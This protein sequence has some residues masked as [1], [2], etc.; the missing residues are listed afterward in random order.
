MPRVSLA[1]LISLLLCATSPAREGEVP[2]EQRPIRISTQTAEPAATAAG[3]PARADDSILDVGRLVMATGIVV[4]LIFG[5]RFGLRKMF[6]QPKHAGRAV[7]MLSRTP[8]SPRQQVMLLKV[9]SRVIVVGDSAGTMR[10]LSEITDPDEVALVIGQAESA[11]ANSATAF[12]SWLGVSRKKYEGEVMPSPE[13]AEITLSTGPVHQDETAG[14]SGEVRQL[15][16][17]VR[18][19]SRQM[20]K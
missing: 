1:I 11:T 7:Q 16:E 19:I 18:S 5:L 3:A 15:L 13:D 20:G 6:V 9:G 12:Q 4:T 8:I 2:F 17:R 14:L 10:T